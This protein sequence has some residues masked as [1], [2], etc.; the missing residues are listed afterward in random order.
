MVTGKGEARGCNQES[1]A[2]AQTKGLENGNEEEML[3]RKDI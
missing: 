1:G 2:G 3:K